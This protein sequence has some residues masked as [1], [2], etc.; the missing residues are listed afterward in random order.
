[1]LSFHIL[2][3]YSP[4]K[5]VEPYRSK[6]VAKVIRIFYKSYESRS[7]A[8]ILARTRDTSVI[9]NPIFY[10]LSLIMS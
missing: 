6:D 1:M 8:Q 10:S 7:I 3:L 5:V 4:V 9:K 2:G